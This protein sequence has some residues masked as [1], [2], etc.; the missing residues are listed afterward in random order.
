MSDATKKSTIVLLTTVGL[1][2]IIALWVVPWQMRQIEESRLENVKQGQS[3]QDFSQTKLVEMLEKTVTANERQ[4]SA[5]QANTAV[6][7][8][9][10]G[11]LEDLCD[12]HEE[13]CTKLDKLIE[14]QV[15]EA[16]H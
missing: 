7:N 8:A 11:K 3:A 16:T 2:T 14:L 15:E 9:Q 5:T 1:G 10:T 12:S 6:M 4:T 13:L